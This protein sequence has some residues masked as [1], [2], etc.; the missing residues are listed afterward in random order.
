MSF[1]SSSGVIGTNLDIKANGGYI[2]VEPSIHPDTGDSYVWELSSHPDD[3]EIAEAPPWLLDKIK[4]PPA[5][6]SADT[7]SERR[8]FAEVLNG[9]PD[10]KRDV[11][12]YK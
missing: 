9:V 5:R 7:K 2:I 10:G 11:E 8:N 4:S 1:G 6:I 3:V 12:V